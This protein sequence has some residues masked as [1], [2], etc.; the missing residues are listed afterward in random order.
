MRPFDTYTPDIVD[1]FLRL[2]IP[3]RED[4]EEEKEEKK[5]R[6]VKESRDKP[7]EMADD[8]VLGTFK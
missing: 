2:S 7:R 1:K 6:G 3:R 4:E 8:T 5:K